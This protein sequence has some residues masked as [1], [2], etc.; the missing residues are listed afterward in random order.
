M[1]SKSYPVLIALALLIAIA[2]LTQVAPAVAGDELPP[3]ATLYQTSPATGTVTF[4]P[5][6]GRRFS[7]IPPLAVMPTLDGARA[8]TREV[9]LSGGVLTATSASG[10]RFTLTVPA[11]ALVVTTTITMTPLSGIAGLPAEELIGAVTLEPAELFLYQPAL[12]AVTPVQ[13]LP[14]AAELTFSFY[15]GG[16]DFHHYPLLLEEPGVV[17]PVMF[18]RSYGLARQGGASIQASAARSAGDYNPGA[19]YWQPAAP[20]SQLAQE[21]AGEVQ[22]E[23]ERRDAG[24]PPDEGWNAEME[25]LVQRYYGQLAA[26]ISFAIC[27][28]TPANIEEV[29]LMLAAC[30]REHG[31]RQVGRF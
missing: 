3:I 28:L 6:T 26:T 22:P 20:W 16:S 19:G 17:L 8:V 5:L 30:R 11:D 31:L 15:E 21:A 27:T 4:L 12:L 29:N 23:R 2:A 25:A 13:P 14:V 24:L 9:P 18:L 10:T 7:R 1:T